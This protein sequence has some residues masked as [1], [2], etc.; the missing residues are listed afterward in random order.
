M[1]QIRRQLDNMAP[2]SREFG[3]LS[4]GNW[5]DGAKIGVPYIVVKGVSSGPCL[6][7][8]GNVHGN[9]MNGVVAAVRFINSIDPKDVHGTLIVTPTANPLGMNRRIKENPLDNQDVDQAF[10]GR[11]DGFITDRMNFA[12]FEEVKANATCVINLHTFGA[13]HHSEPYAVYKVQDGGSVPEDLLLK[14]TSFFNPSVSCRMNV[15]GAGE[16]PGNVAGA[17]DYQCVIR[18]IPAFMVELG[19]ASD[20]QPEN[21]ELAID[22]FVNLSKHLKLLSGE[23]RLNKS[24][25]RVTKRTWVMSDKGGLFLKSVAAKDIVRK[26][27]EFGEL[28]SIDGREKTRL[29]SEQDCIVI[30][31]QRD[32][33]L[34]SGEAYAF[35]GTEWDEY[36]L[37][38]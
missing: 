10:P 15:S 5:A 20:Y 4:I 26:G 34:H 30:G 19:R 31:I 2:G 37:A 12:I 32:P 23:A 22:G 7:L 13:V 17:L 9:E 11:P 38:W 27:E 25:R 35:V 29:L 14:Y 28:W 6:W 24:V 33:V 18:G 3:E 21:V 36:P 16:L 8:N 1:S